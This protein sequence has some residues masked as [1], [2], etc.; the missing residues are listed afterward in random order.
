M[1]STPTRHSSPFLR[2]PRPRLHPL[3]CSAFSLNESTCFVLWNCSKAIQH[4]STVPRGKRRFFSPV[5][6][7]SNFIQPTTIRKCIS[8]WLLYRNQ[9]KDYLDI[10]RIL[11][12]VKIY[13]WYGGSIIL[14]SRISCSIKVRE[15]RLYEPISFSL[16]YFFHKSD[17]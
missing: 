4:Q 5:D 13:T 7:F 1:T 6:Y 17:N 16:F 8:H 9:K 15:Q 12:Q 10:T 14:T 11:Y 3:S 2:V